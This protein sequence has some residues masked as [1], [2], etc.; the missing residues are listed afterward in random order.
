[1]KAN[2]D[3]CQLLVTRDTDVTVKIGKFDFKNSREEV[4]LGSK[5]DIKLSFKNHV[6]SFCKK[7]SQKLH[8]LARIVNFV[9]LAKRKNLMKAFTTSQFNKCPLIWN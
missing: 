9:D 3:K 6:S 7:A 4:L 1:M 8:A 5:I 2:T